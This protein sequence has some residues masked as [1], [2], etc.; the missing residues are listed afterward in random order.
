[1]S[2]EQAAPRKSKKLGRGLSA[3]LGDDDTEDTGA[4]DSGRGER[5]GRS[6]PIGS[7]KA[8]PFQPRRHFNQSDLEDLANSIREQG[9][10]QPILVRR[11][12]NSET[13]EIIAGERR[14]RAAQMAQIHEV[15][16]LVRELDDETALEIAIIENVQRRDLLHIE[17]AEGY[18]RLMDE[19]GHT[20]E[21]VAQSVGKSRSYV[22]N[23]V[24]LLN[25]P[26]DVRDMLREEKISSGHA[27]ALLM[28]DDP[29]ELAREVVAK[30]LNVRQTERLA[31]QSRMEPDD[32]SSSPP[33]SRK[34]STQSHD[35]DAD[36][37][38]L[39]RDLSE[40]LGM[41]VSI[42]HDTAS[43]AGELAIKYLS[44][45]QLD[46]LIERLG[47][48]GTASHSTRSV[49]VAPAD[50]APIPSD[51]EIDS[52]ELDEPDQND[53][54][55]TDPIAV[56]YGETLDE[57]SIFNSPLSGLD[58]S[59][60]EEEAEDDFDDDDL[61]LIDDEDRP[62]P[63][64]AINP[65]PDGSTEVDPEIELSLDSLIDD[66]PLASLT[67]AAADAS[68]AGGDAALAA[69][70]GASTEEAF[71]F[72]EGEEDSSETDADDLDD[73]DDEDLD[74]D[75]IDLDVDDPLASLTEATGDMGGGGDAALT[76]LGARENT[77]EEE[78]EDEDLT[79]LDSLTEDETEEEVGT[80]E[81]AASGEFPSWPFED[82]DE[83]DE[84][85]D[86][87]LDLDL[88]LEEDE[89]P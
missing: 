22:A 16:V 64:E 86:L 33:K 40:K 13:Y 59:E 76:A 8:G 17:E 50:L 38:A 39:E 66:D 72:D 61:D 68:T 51:G 36:T 7:L 87:D 45:E 43:G 44:L 46:G 9:V 42:T 3:L 79:S 47:T 5:G 11:D 52:D 18:R 63:L 20:Q 83:D 60:E 70:G 56:S 6:I 89:K 27:R 19:F 80:S 28:A 53:D 26:E 88:D 2:D 67:E 71:E 21:E 54:I 81:A 15:P 10:L 23:Q 24:R 35:K 1:M 48:K 78:D 73:D 32:S 65:D 31:Q 69:L 37:I 4:E 41:L 30:S 82:E 25:L 75:S 62:D 14:W 49:A 34:Q 12:Q 57:S 74:L 85:E 77:A 55:E 84:D 58:L 29:S